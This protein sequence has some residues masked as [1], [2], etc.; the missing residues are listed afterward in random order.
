[1]ICSAWWDTDDTFCCPLLPHC[2]PPVNIELQIK[3]APKTSDLLRSLPHDMM[4]MQSN[5]KGKKLEFKSLSEAGNQSA[6]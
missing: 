2:V 3:R 6:V 4:P 5:I 1:M